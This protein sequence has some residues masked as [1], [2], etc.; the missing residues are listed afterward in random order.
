MA[1]TSIYSREN[2]AW[3]YRGFGKR[4][5]LGTKNKKEA[6]QLKKQ[7]DNRFIVERANGILAKKPVPMLSRAIHN[8]LQYKK[9][10]F[11]SATLKNDRGRLGL[12]KGYVGDP[13]LDTI[14]EETLVDYMNY[15]RYE[16]GVSDRCLRNDMTCVKAMILYYVKR[17]TLKINPF[18]HIKLLNP[19][20]NTLF[21]N[22][23]EFDK[24]YNL[25]YPNRRWI[26][27]FF[28]IALHTG[29]RRGEMATLRWDMIDFE[30]KQMIGVGKRGYVHFPIYPKL[31][32]E[33][34]SI[35]YKINGE[36]KYGWK[37]GYSEWVFHKNVNVQGNNN[38]KLLRLS[39][40]WLTVC[41]REVFDHLNFNKKYTLHSLRHT[42]GAHLYMSGVPLERIQVLMGHKSISMTQKYAHITV[43]GDDIANSAYMD[44]FK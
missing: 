42:F 38:I 31:E 4:V 3:Y 15:R 5:S 1:N 34:K 17:E 24:L 28:R 14:T 37:D 30:K 12:F 33:L 11:T 39:E 25:N 10:N 13:I 20:S 36:I 21:L 7:Y 19:H 6:Q 2:G 40:N 22:H 35:S 23:I 29:F 27:K 18:A 43:S 41:T 8:Y 16:K 44:M 32:K 26:E 9:A